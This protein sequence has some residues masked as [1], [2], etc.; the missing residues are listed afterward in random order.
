[1]GIGL[2]VFH[3]LEKGHLLS[4]I[5]LLLTETNKKLTEHALTIDVSPEVKEW[6]LNKYYQP[7]YGARP[8]RR[9]IAREIED[10]LSEEL[11][12]GRFKNTPVV[13]VNL[14]QDKPVFV[15]AE[16]SMLVSVN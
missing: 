7:A 2:S 1:V 10:Y 6:L 8:M 4:I 11:I 14:E 16:E 13:R 5:D 3:P 15:E 9:A 12:K